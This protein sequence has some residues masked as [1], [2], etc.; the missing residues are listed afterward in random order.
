MPDT[1][2]ELPT[3]TNAGLK[4]LHKVGI[5]HFQ[6][7]YVNGDI[8][9][10]KTTAEYSL[11]PMGIVAYQ[12]RIFDNKPKGRVIVVCFVPETEQLSY[13]WTRYNKKDGFIEGK[14]VIN[15]DDITVEALKRRLNEEAYDNDTVS[16]IK[17][18]VEDF[19]E[20][21]RGGGE[22]EEDE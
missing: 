14:E 2:N 3:I 11:C 20:Y 5:L 16:Y 19:I 8:Q 21:W 22:H 15:E 12:I 10:L 17:G 1:N 4:R 13:Q 18:V 9:T 6:N 7:K